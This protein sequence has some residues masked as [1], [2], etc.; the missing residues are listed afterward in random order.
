MPRAYESI[1]HMIPDIIYKLD[2]DGCFTYINNSIRNLGYEPE[3]LIYK[4]FSMLIHPDD[5]DNVRRDVVLKRLPESSQPSDAH[6]KLF[7][8]RRTGKRITRDLHVRLIPKDYS[9]IVNG[10]GDVMATCR[11]ISV[12]SYHAIPDGEE[13]EFTGTLGVI[14]D[15]VNIKK[16]QETL[17]RCIDYYQLLVEL[18][19]DVFFVIATDG[20]VLFSSA[21]LDRILG[22]ASGD[23]TGENIIDYIHTDDLKPIVRS[24]WGMSDDNHVFFG[25]GRFLNRDNEWRS[26]DIRS[27]TVYDE[28]GKTLY[29]TAI[30]HDISARVRAEDELKRAHSELE[31]RIADRTA[32]LSTANELLQAEIDNRN[33][34]EAILLSSEKKYRTLV[35]SIDDI[36]L[37][38]D[39]EGSVLFA[40]PA[41][42]KITG[43]DQREVIG[44]NLMEFIH[45]DDIESFL[46]ALRKG[47]SS[48]NAGPLKLIETICEDKELRLVK[49]DGIPIWV[50]LRCR[51]VTDDAG[52]IMGF[53]G[54]AHDITRRKLIEEEMLRQGKIESLAIL[55][56][57]IAHDFNNLLTAIIG[58]LSLAKIKIMPSDPNYLILTEAENASEMAKNLTQQLMAFSRGGFSDK[59]VTPIRSLLEDTAYFVL[60][61]SG[62]LCEFRIR[63]D[64]WEAEIDRGQ[65]SQVIHNIVLNARQAMPEGG[66]ITLYAENEVVDARAGLPLRSGNYIKICLEDQ[67]KGI[68]DDILPRIFDPYFSTKESGSGL[69][70]AIS[71]SIVKKHDGLITAE[72][73]PGSGSIFTL[74][75]PAIVRAPE[76]ETPALVRPA[77]PKGGRI[78]LMDDEKIVLD[79]GG[80]LLAHLGYDVVC[81]SNGHEAVELFKKAKD[82]G[83]PFDVVIMDLI[84][85]DGS[86]ADRA[87][88]G[89]KEID[90]DVRTIVTSGYADDPAMVRYAEHGFTGAIA[91]PFSLEELD[92]ELVRVMKQ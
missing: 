61:G 2:A 47:G 26:F 31:A 89:L 67:G 57:G 58:N 75:L 34:Q 64:L 60:R 56:A 9:V 83:V 73:R 8:E 45:A 15:V 78:L 46:A 74:R 50:E 17:L 28:N 21:S 81:V 49:K 24:F 32:A 29:I 86:G 13:R 39:P 5:V 53:R 35:N 85:P 3:E 40:N 55:A 20:T 69:G 82:D 59:K 76:E 44:R 88:A 91:K 42:L 51:P 65:I 23:M 54:I 33:R 25:E 84:I 22:Y 16:S 36:V 71:Y 11:V 80:R 4:H 18:S 10:G 14:K 19:N 72:S 41:I 77:A 1:V 90:P 68:P 48:V 30:I 92:Q 37:N 79:M 43:Y 87:I 63:D 12:G 66:K 62:I 6:P 38:I 70:L 52:A 7:D 27:R